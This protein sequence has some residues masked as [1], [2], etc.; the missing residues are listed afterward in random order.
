MLHV[1]HEVMTLFDRWTDKRTGAWNRERRQA[2]KR[3]DSVKS[4]PLLI[5][6]ESIFYPLIIFFFTLQT[7]CFHFVF[8]HRP[9]KDEKNELFAKKDLCQKFGFSLTCVLN[10]KLLKW[11]ISS[12]MRW[13]DIRAMTNAKFNREKRATSY[14]QFEKWNVVIIFLC[15][16]INQPTL[17]LLPLNLYQ[18]A[19]KVNVA[20]S[21]SHLDTH[22]NERTNII[23]HHFSLVLFLV[24]ISG[25]LLERNF[26]ISL[27]KSHFQ[28]SQFGSIPVRFSIQC[29]RVFRK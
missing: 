20:R 8:W 13:G 27:L 12:S 28:L 21:L 3:C 5:C 23:A 6:A 29:S 22:R 1:I 16:S 7:P 2:K 26:L 4:N 18:Q 14:F 25:L 11:W 17:G 19:S 24:H 9:K 15:F 10:F